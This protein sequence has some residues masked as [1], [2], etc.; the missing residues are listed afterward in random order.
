MIPSLVLH[1]AFESVELAAVALFFVA[2]L[3]TAYEKLRAA[4]R[5][6]GLWRPMRWILAGSFVLNAAGI[7]WGLPSTW[8]VIETVPVYVLAA[9]T[10]HFSHGWFELYPPLQYYM[11]S[12]VGSPVLLLHSIDVVSYYTPTG[13]TLLIL[14]YRLLSL[15]FGAG[16]LATVAFTGRRAFGNRAAVLAAGIAAL[17]APFVYYS[18]TANVD[19]PYVFWYSV[20]LLYLLRL[21]QE[22]RLRDYVL[23]AVTATLAVCTK[24]Q[25]YAL[26]PTVPVLVVIELWR[27]KRRDGVSW[28]L[29]RA[30]VD[31]RIVAAVLAAVTTVVVV[32]NLIFNLDGFVTHVRSTTTAAAPYAVFA[33]TFAGEWQLL[34]LTVRL[35]RDSMGWPFFVAG[36]A[37]L[38]IGFFTP[39]LRRTTVWLAAAIPAYYLVSDRH[40]ALQLRSVHAAG[41]HSCWPSS[42]VLRSIVCC[43]L[44]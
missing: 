17:V 6:D 18:K 35:V 9:L 38:T 8:A 1:G 10:M 21:L 7:W 14:S 41:L 12:L 15:I 33:P 27:Q 28:P 44:R 31:R 11:L 29:V 40:R 20:S 32:C 37:G 2:C 24:D 22:S 4:L 25:A 13:S 42:A 23:F 36:V 26:Y 43:P 30:F 39:R 3:A 34:L 5:R 16:T 19:V